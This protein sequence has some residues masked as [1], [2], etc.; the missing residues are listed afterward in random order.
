MI[1]KICP[2]CNTDNP[3]NAVF[4][5]K[6]GALFVGQPEFVNLE[7][8]KAKKITDLKNKVVVGI[9]IVLLVVALVIFKSG[10]TKN[11]ETVYR[12]RPLI[13]KPP[14]LPQRRLLLQRRLQRLL[15]R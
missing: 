14:P 5:K 1:R 8:K 11:D 9:C 2:Y 12:L 6:C 10:S 15:L 13:Q 7:E 4:C 3:E